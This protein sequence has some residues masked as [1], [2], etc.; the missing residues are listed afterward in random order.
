M[1]YSL[2]T[3]ARDQSCRLTG[4]IEA[5]ETAHIIPKREES[6]FAQQN[7]HDL[8]RYRGG[9]DGLGNLLLLRSDVHLVF[10]QLK[11]VMFPKE[12]S[13]W[14]YYALDDSLDLASV[15]HNRSL[16]PIHG[17][18]AEYLL[19]GF[20]RAIFPWLNTFIRDM[21][22]K[23][24]FGTTVGTNDAA[25]VKVSG[26]WCFENILPPGQRTRNNSPKKRQSPNKRSR[27]NDGELKHQDQDLHQDQVQDLNEPRIRKLP[28]PAFA[29]PCI[30]LV[31]PLTPSASGPGSS[32]EDV[33]P[34]KP[35]TY[36]LSRDCPN[37]K[38]IARLEEIRQRAL[39]VEREKSDVTDWW[40]EQVEWAQ[41]ALDN[42]TTAGNLD[43]F[44]WAR[45]EEVLDNKGEYVDTK[46][47][48]LDNV[49]WEVEC[50]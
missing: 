28:N 26:A 48:F 4:C 49:A 27:S 41:E 15:Y 16:R 11:W 6:W 46:A 14:V 33:E 18:R 38:D 39:E 21:K 7:M 32:H 25:G 22:D 43:R 35:S 17:V 31:L 44:F 23:Y 12:G 10:D 29:G 30:C 34:P 1:C 42:N 5:S 47:E 9:V 45:G 36:C 50:S 8:E 13:T 2:I 20:A 3:H 37:R 24:L 19:V 40:K